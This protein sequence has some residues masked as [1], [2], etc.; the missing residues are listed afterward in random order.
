MYL[1]SVA[2]IILLNC[3]DILVC[4]DMCDIGTIDFFLAGYQNPKPNKVY[5]A[6]YSVKI[7][8]GCLSTRTKSKHSELYEFFLLAEVSIFLTFLYSWVQSTLLLLQPIRNYTVKR[9]SKMYILKHNSWKSEGHW[10]E[11]IDCV[12]LE[13]FCTCDIIQ[14]SAWLVLSFAILLNRS[15]TRITKLW[16]YQKRVCFEGNRILWII[17]WVAWQAYRQFKDTVTHY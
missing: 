16:A 2:N 17:E 8:S 13:F 11:L 4:I 3:C 5:S 15:L 12:G 1:V 10:F 9:G 6:I 14:D 7:R